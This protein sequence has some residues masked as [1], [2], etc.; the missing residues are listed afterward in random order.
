MTL[1]NEADK[2]YIGSTPADRVYAGANL[3]WEAGAPTST[4]P[5]VRSS[6]HVAYVG[7]RTTT[8]VPAPASIVN[9]DQMF[10]AIFTGL[11]GGPHSAQAVTPPAG[12]SVIPGSPIQVIDGG[13]YHG[14]FEVFRKVASSEGG[15][16]AFTHDTLATSGHIVAVGGVNASIPI[17]AYSTN[18]GAGFVTT[19]LG[20]TTTVPNTL[21]LNLMFNWAAS[22]STA[23]LAGFTEI[24]DAL[25]VSGWKNQPAAGATGN[26]TQ[27][28]NGNS[29][30]TNDRWGAFLLALRPA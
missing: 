9:G 10:A 3:V 15:E 13:S 22:G 28:P 5:A 30:P 4:P 2:I 17:D 24:L 12:W 18:S 25:I 1:L 11:A 20:V 19:V 16:Y 26:F 6:S 27:N 29:D 7:G 21:L 8:Y 14:R 23:P